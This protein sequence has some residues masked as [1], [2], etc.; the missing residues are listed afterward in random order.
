V[1]TA[2]PL[3][4]KAITLSSRKWGGSGGVEFVRLSFGRYGDDVAR[5]VGDDE[6]QKWAVGDLATVFGIDVQPIES[7]V[8]RWLDAMPQYGPG[9]AGLVARLRDGLPASLA[10]AGNYLEGI[11]VPACIASGTAAAASLLAS[12]VAR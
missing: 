3:R 10:L 8:A 6:L 1:A 9:H 5:S 7:H 12:P 4:A 2:E 11:G